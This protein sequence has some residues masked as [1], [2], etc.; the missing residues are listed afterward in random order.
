M[1]NNNNNSSKTKNFIQGLRPLSSSVPHGLKNII[2]KNGYNFSNIVDNWNNIVNKN[3]SNLCYPINVKVGKDMSNAT[4]V[5]N[6]IHGNE[7]NIE[8]A[9]KEIIDKINSFFGYNYVKEI[10]LKVVHENKIDKKFK[11]KFL[12][13]DKL[14]K[15]QDKIN[16]IKN[17]NLK[18]SLSKLLKAY[19]AKNN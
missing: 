14:Y 10:K 4:I 2:K 18:G 8:Y 12:R 17:I 1:H 5:L 11:T 15:Y 13:N 7:L 9:K 16:G 19:N 6:V 3:I